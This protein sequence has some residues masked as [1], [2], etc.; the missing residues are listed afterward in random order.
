MSIH[1]NQLYPLLFFVPVVGILLFTYKQFLSKQYRK[2]SVF[3]LITLT[4]IILAL[5]GI[6]LVNDAKD[7]T[8]IFLADVSNSTL[9]KRD[10][11]TEFIHDA[12]KA[13]NNA[14]LLG[15][16]GF[17]TGANI[18]SIPSKSSLFTEFQASIDGEFTNIQSG[19]I[20]ANAVIP[21]D[22]KRRIVLMTDGYENIG[23]AR[24]QLG[25]LIDSD[26]AIDVVDLSDHDFSE[27]QFEEIIIPSKVDK[28]QMVDIKAKIHSN[29]KTT[30]TLY[31]YS[32]NQVKY[33]TEINIDQGENL[34]VFTD[35]ITEGG[36]VTYSA[37]IIVDEDTYT[38]NNFVSTYTFVN[39][40]PKILIVQGEDEQALNL[41]G[42]LENSADIDIRRPEEVPSTL[43]EIIKYDGYI[44]SNISIEL[45]NQEFLVSVEE[46][47]RLQGKGLLVTGGET[48]YGPGGYYKTI[49]EDMLPV[50]MDAKPKEEKPNLALMLI[51]DKSGSMS[52]GEFGITQMELAKEAAIRSIDIL[53]GKDYIGVIG[54]DSEPKWVV[55]TVKVIDKDKIIDQIASLQPGGGTSI[56]PSLREGIEALEDIDAGLKHIILLTDGQAESTGYLPLL[57]TLKEEGMTLSTVAVGSGADKGL[58]KLLAEYGNGRYYSTD[59]FSDIPS[60]FTKEAFMAGKK[61]LNNVTFYP[62]VTADSPI[63]SGIDGLPE[64]DGY[65]A[66]SPKEQGKVILSGPDDDPIL[67]TWQYGL[68]RTIAFTS[69]MKGIWTENWLIWDANQ[70][71]WINTMSWLVQQD[72]NTDYAV[73][74]R[75]EG[76][77]G[78][79][80]VKSLVKNNDYASIE[81]LLSSPEG[82]TTSIT[83]EAVAPGKYKGEFEPDGKGVYLVSL[84][85]GEGEEAEQVITAVN[86]GYSKEFDFFGHANITIDELV[87]LSGGRLITKGSEVFK[88]DVPDVSGSRDLSR[89]LLILAFISFILEITLRKFK[90]PVATVTTSVKGATT[91]VTNIFRKKEKVLDESV[92]AHVN[93][94]LKNKKKR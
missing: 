43:E 1:F 18:E 88:G 56:Q 49:L 68:G 53:E 85:L 35:E 37:Q 84:N 63:I 33:E 57:E 13:K 65:V 60:I 4:L 9:D 29:I 31:I 66:T 91:R 20:S 86:I 71:F 27:V 36:L 54:F 59:V 44:L 12:M 62:R 67:A 34:F 23:D 21:N 89:M 42:M 15:V 19:L 5:C 76:G 28:D 75:Y 81:G 38:E 3:R 25:A 55:D 6:H 16:V 48:S 58:L 8:T 11:M 87:K 61:Y 7:T 93:E 24:K 92:G 51:I 90:P 17:G 45:L 46:A 94:L 80:D 39:D 2:S 78:I 14:D 64:L 50:N 30:G 70:N 10:E 83:L 22:T 69:D 52:G 82:E 41:I 32:N 47:I 40:L 72:L 73:D 26:T 79:I 74:G 77:K